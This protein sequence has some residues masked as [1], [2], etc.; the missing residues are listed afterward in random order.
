MS[1]SKIT[2]EYVVTESQAFASLEHVTYGCFS[3]LKIHRAT[4]RLVRK[5]NP[6]FTANSWLQCGY[7]VVNIDFTEFEYLT[8][9]RFYSL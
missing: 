9:R 6:S 1:S 2:Q 8:R 5:H 4:W 3:L 7:N